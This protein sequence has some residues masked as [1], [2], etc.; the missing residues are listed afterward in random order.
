MPPSECTRRNYSP[1]NNSKCG[2]GNATTR[3]RQYQG[4][5]AFI[6]ENLMTRNDVGQIV[7]VIFPNKFSADF[8]KDFEAC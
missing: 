4:V 7:K 6:A 3:Q 1:A 5:V 2:F 8:L